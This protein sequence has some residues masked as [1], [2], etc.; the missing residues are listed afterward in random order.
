MQNVLRSY[1]FARRSC[2]TPDWDQTVYM[3]DSVNHS[4]NFMWVIPSRDTCD[5]MYS[6]PLLV[7]HEQ[8]E[9]LNFVIDFKEGILLK[10]CKKLNNEEA[11]SPFLIN[12]GLICHT[13]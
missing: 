9:L 11:D 10:R 12:K 13:T 1:F 2:P 8:R 6:N 3:V 5:W 4:I 7:P